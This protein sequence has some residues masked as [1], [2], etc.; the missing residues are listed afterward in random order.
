MEPWK[1]AR[2]IRVMVHACMY[3]S[4]PMY[5]ITNLDPLITAESKP[6]ESKLQRVVDNDALSYHCQ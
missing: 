5:I 4:A 6:A 2:Y 3:M 1:N